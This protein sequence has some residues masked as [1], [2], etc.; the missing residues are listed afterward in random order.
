[1][2]YR[3]ESHVRTA[4]SVLLVAAMVAVGG[5]AVEERRPAAKIELPV[6]PPAP[7]TP[8]FYYERTLYSS[9]NVTT[10]D[11]SSLERLVTGSVRTGEGLEKPYGVAAFKGRIYVTDSVRNAVALFDIPGRKFKWFGEEGKGQVR[12]PLGIDLD[13]QGNVYVA[14]NANK[15]V[16]IYDAEGRYEN[17]IGGSDTGLF[18]RPVGI[19]VDGEGKRLY[20]VD[21]GGV[22]ND[23]HRVRVFE[24]PSR[25]H[26]FDIGKRG[27]GDGEFNLPRDAAIA[28]NGNLFVVDGANFRVQVFDRDGRFLR[29]FGEIGRRSGQFARPKEVAIDN[30]G[31]AYIVDT[32][33]GNFQIFDGDGRLLLDVGGRSTS[34]APAKYLLP[35]GIAIDGDGRVYVVDQYFRKVDIYRPASLQPNQG[36]VAGSAAPKPPA[37]P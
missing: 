27:N 20:V 8:R 26:L 32:A 13:G 33:F 6:F 25:K 9:A 23:N 30:S 14:D 15:R 36:Y 10:D 18:S 7:E 1:M 16:V 37:K 3:I 29:V 4:C 17:E 21:T 28:P 2:V 34:D 31:N 19:A 22:D 24:L 35:S 11:V 12:V 5:C